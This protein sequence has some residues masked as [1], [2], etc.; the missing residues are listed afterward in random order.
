[1]TGAQNVA[2]I[3]GV[4]GDEPRPLWSV[5]IPT[6]NCARFL[7]ETLDSVLEQDPG[8]E[9]M[10]IIV[11][12]DHSDQDDPAE[13]VERKG[14]SR[15]RFIRQKQNVGKVRNYETGLVE[16]RGRLIHQLH[17]DDRVKPGFYAAMEHAFERFPDAGA[18]FCESLYITETGA[19]IGR[20]GIERSA[21]GLLDDWLKKIVVA[22]RIQ[23]PSIVMRR[24]VY[25]SV[26]GFDRRLDMSE[27]W[28]MWIR[29]ANS[30]PVGF[31]S[32]PLAEYRMSPSNNSTRAMLAGTRAAALRSV[33]RIVDEYLPPHVVEECRTERDREMAQYL[34][35]FIPHLMIAH[36]YKGVARVYRDALR[37][38]ID[39]RTCYRLINYTLR[40]K[41]LLRA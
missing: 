5:L 15:V 34:I 32:Q 10:E 11:V 35:Q 24:E 12:D 29:V 3:P 4:R 14:G 38:S 21:T 22:Q 13:V 25:E 41:A 37:F 40:Y 7:G 33:M 2:T 20:T 23:T 18:F 1:M 30:Y 17:G 19:V 39:P 6:F 31:L 27:D 16:S 36:K 28:E 26:G 8:P 9:Q